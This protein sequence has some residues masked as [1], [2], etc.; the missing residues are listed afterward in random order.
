MEEE[1][2][3]GWFGIVQ[4]V[5]QIDTPGRGHWICR[6]RIAVWS[7]RRRWQEGHARARH[8]GST[9]IKASLKGER[10]QLLNE[11]FPLC[12]DISCLFRPNTLQ[13]ARALL[14]LMLMVIVSRSDTNLVQCCRGTIVRRSFIRGCFNRSKTWFYVRLM[15]LE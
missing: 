4:G 12:T 14:S 6:F 7:R 1:Q 3:L 5:F 10:V 8:W 2:A 9:P 13:A 11:V 15:Y